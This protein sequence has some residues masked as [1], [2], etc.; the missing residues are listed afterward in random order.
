MRIR[1]VPSGSSPTCAKHFHETAETLEQRLRPDLGPSPDV[2]ILRNIIFYGAPGTGK[3]YVAK[4]AAAALTGDEDPGIDSRW[5][6]VQFHPSYA[7]EDFVQGMRPTLEAKDLRYKLQQAPFPVICKAAEDDPDHFHVLVIDEVNRG[8]PA[9]IFGELLYALEYRGEAVE[10]AT[11]GSLAVPPNLVVLGTMNSVDRSVALVDYALRRRFAFVRVAPAPSIIDPNRG[12]VLE[13]FNE[14]LE[15]ELDAD[16]VIGH[17]V[18]LNP[19]LAQLA[20]G[21]ALDRIWRNDV[22]PL[23][24]EY[25]FGRPDR[26][27]AAKKA[28]DAARSEA[29]DDAS[30]GEAHEDPP[31]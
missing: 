1:C 7:Y 22:R 28:W 2:S 18:F 26:L 11:G 20:A 5:R 6:I 23:L 10:L 12:T 29:E 16:H 24:E 3:T 13:A 25:F 15:K 21:E 27:K 14:W 19:A 8:D 4:M 31:P 30:D 17:S 9:R